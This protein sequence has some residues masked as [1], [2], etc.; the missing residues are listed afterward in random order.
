M[1]NMNCKIMKRIQFKVFKWTVLI[2]RMDNYNFLSLQPI[3][4][5]T[6]KQTYV[7]NI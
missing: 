7:F 1:K 4:I 3:T 2:N 5:K 6:T